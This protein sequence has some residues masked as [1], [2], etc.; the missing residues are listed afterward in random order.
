MKKTPH[1]NYCEI[2]SVKHRHLVKRLVAP[3]NDIPIFGGFVFGLVLKS[4]HNAWLS[5]TPRVT[6]N[7]VS[8]GL[9]RADILLDFDY[10]KES[11]V[12]FP[13]NLMQINHFEPTIHQI[14][15]RIGLYSGYCYSKYCDDCCI[16]V[17]IN[18]NKKIKH[19]KDFYKKTIQQVENFSDTFF[20]QTQDIFLNLLPEI[21]VSRF[22]TDP[23]FRHRI[24]TSQTLKPTE[25]DLTEKELAIL[26]WTARGKSAADIAIIIGLSK[27]TI[28]TYRRTIISKLNVSNITEAVYLA[29][30]MHLIV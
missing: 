23:I 19:I 5:S 11:R 12:I 27:N 13:E 8:S 6:I 18:T 17:G 29:L 16:I 24:L 22:I 9:S 7:T 15:Q 14:M 26:Y 3:L 2:P 28:D 30:S 1:I 4:G 10:L 25:I 21:K 20:N